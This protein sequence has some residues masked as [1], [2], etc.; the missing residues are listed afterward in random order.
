MKLRR[1]VMDNKKFVFILSHV[2]SSP[3]EVLGIMKVASNMKAFSDETEIA[4]FLINEGVLLAKKGVVDDMTMEFEGKPVNFKEMLDMLI[5]FGVKFYVCHGFMP[6]F[7]ITKENMIEGAEVKSS[8][9]LGELLLQG[10]IPFSL[11]L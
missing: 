11:G 1:N 8:S 9:Y 10:Y 2:T 7:G 6:G 3:V 5:E 4:V